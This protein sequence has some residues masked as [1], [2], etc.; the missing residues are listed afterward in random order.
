MRHKRKKERSGESTPDQSEA[1]FNILLLVRPEREILESPKLSMLS[2]TAILTQTI[3]NQF[4][5]E[6]SAKLPTATSVPAGIPLHSS[7]ISILE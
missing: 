2:W 7:Y 3:G 1:G 5:P 4:R 6:P